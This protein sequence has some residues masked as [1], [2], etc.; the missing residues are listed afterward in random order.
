MAAPASL[1]PPSS[2]AGAFATLSARN[3][4]NVIAKYANAEGN[5]RKVAQDF[6][7]SFLNSMFSQMFTNIDGEGPFGGGP[8]VGVWRS[9]LTEE[10]SKS[11]AKKGGIGIADEVYRA[12]LA[13]QEITAAKPLGVKGLQK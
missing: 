11:F 12:L 3:D 5:A 1:V 7:A 13:Q 10:Y 4:P 9:F 2:A 8:A 6:E